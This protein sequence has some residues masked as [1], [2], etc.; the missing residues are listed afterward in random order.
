MMIKRKNSSCELE[1]PSSISFRAENKSYFVPVGPDVCDDLIE[2]YAEGSIFT[3]HASNL[4][5]APGNCEKQSTMPFSHHS[6]YISPG[7]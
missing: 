7:S 1:A 2:I 4:K 6:V 5:P 3:I